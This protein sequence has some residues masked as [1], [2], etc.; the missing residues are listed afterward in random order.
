M[1]M[2]LRLFLS[3]SRLGMYVNRISVC[4]VKQEDW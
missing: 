2:K 4:N 3:I 1:E